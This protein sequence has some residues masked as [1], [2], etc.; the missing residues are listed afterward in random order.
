MDNYKVYNS[1]A[2]KIIVKV[3]LIKVI[4]LYIVISLVRHAKI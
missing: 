2:H 4:L 3:A 1:F